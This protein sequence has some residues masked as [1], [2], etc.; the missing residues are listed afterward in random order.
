MTADQEIT[1]YLYDHLKKDSVVVDIGAYTGDW[2][3]GM[4]SKIK[5][6][7]KNFYLVEADRTNFTLCKKKHPKCKNIFHIA[8]AHHSD[9][10]MMYSANHERAEG[11]SQSNS[12]FREYMTAK[13]WAQVESNR[14][15]GSTMDAFFL[16]AGVRHADLVKIN[17]EGGEYQIFK[18]PTRSWL[19][20]TNLIYIQFH[21]KCDKFLSP[22]FLKMRRKIQGAMRLSGFEKIMGEE[23]PRKEGGHVHQL[24]GRK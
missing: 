11:S 5:G 16:N 17:C 20:A 21:G 12:L 19:K 4:R 14:V 15:M 7:W 3:E 6:A 8:I 18:A 13:N 22:Q 9:W 2:S 23:E 24:W 10:V 1:Q